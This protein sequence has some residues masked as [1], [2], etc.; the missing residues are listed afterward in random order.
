MGQAFFCLLQLAHVGYVSRSVCGN[1]ISLLHRKLWKLS[2]S[3]AGYYCCS[4]SLHI[5]PGRKLRGY[6]L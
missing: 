4:L 1:A 2:E 6:L 3:P 5:W